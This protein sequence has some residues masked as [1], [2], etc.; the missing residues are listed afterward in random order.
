MIAK[1]LSLVGS[2]EFEGVKSKAVLENI[3]LDVNIDSGGIGAIHLPP[4]W[5]IPKSMKTVMFK[6]NEA[7]YRLTANITSMEFGDI[8]T[9]NIDGVKIWP[10]KREAPLNKE[11]LYDFTGR[12]D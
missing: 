5:F 9:I 8:L 10:C 3:R 7:P 2:I 1:S 11:G 4:E 12:R 6:I